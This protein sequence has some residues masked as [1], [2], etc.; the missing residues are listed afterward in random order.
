MCL[1]IRYLIY[2][3]KNNLALNNLQWLI[4]HKT[5]PNQTLNGKPLKSVNQFIYLSSNISSTESE[6]NIR[7]SKVWNVFKMQTI[8]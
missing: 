2:M 8:V 4:C 1:E 3:N 6:V 5:K 7:I